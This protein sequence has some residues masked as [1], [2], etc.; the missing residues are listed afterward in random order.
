ME[1]PRTGIVRLEPDG[2][3]APSVAD[4]DNVSTHGV[5]IIWLGEITSAFDDGEWMLRTPSMNM[6]KMKARE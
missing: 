3:V 6:T 2:N 1:D 5:N 4:T